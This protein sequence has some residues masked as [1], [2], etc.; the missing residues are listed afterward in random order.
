MA[1]QLFLITSEDVGKTGI[2]RY[3]VGKYGVMDSTKVVYIRKTS[4]K[5]ERLASLL[6]EEERNN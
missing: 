5:A 3:D 4:E 6:R 1:V 2:K